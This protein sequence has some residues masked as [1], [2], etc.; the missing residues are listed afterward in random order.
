M[1][2][3]LD[4]EKIL[5]VTPPQEL[6]PPGEAPPDDK[7]AKVEDKP[8]ATAGPGE[9]APAPADDTEAPKE[10]P[11]KSAAQRIADL[12]A[13]RRETERE[14]QELREELA[15][16][17][18]PPRPPALKD[19]HPSQFQ[20]TEAYNDAVREAAFTEARAVAQQEEATKA[21]ERRKDDFFGKLAKEGKGIE[22]FDDV[23]ASVREDK[24]FIH[25]S[26]PM[27][28]YLMEDADHPAQVLKW[29]ADNPD[30]S[31]R[32]FALSPT[33][34]T[35]EL[36]RRDGLLG[37]KA[38]P[39]VSRAPAPTPSVTGS[40]SAPQSIERMSHDDLLKWTRE[41]KRK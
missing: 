39:P 23:L 38:A 11:G 22:G 27:A 36:V 10:P 5:G 15:R 12:T 21:A 9:D 7:G 2:E 13:K 1:P 31:E 4:F 14:N 19:L 16:R 35:K 40:G 29:L 6:T 37:R 17:G 3:A 30:E 18:G 28:Q 34:A 41:Q 32:I 8:E 33:A 24:S 26:A 25:I 20:T